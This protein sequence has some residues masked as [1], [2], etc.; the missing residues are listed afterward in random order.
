M[1]SCWL[2]CRLRTGPTAVKS[3]TNSADDRIF[4]HPPD[5]RHAKRYEKQIEGI[6]KRG[7]QL[8]QAE[9]PYHRTPALLTGPESHPLWLIHDLDR[10]DKHRELVLTIA[11]FEISATG[12]AGSF[13]ALYRRIGRPEQEIA[14][15]ARTLAPETQISTRIA[16]KT[17][18]GRTPQE[19]ITGLRSLRD[20]VV[21]L[22][23]RFDEDCFSDSED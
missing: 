10:I 19:V 13:V 1:S 12:M 6:D 11:A 7:R 4:L 15:L 5:G 23:Q 21:K 14:E 8:I 3:P 2:F 17:F 18:G 9:Q 20:Y 16:F 22:A